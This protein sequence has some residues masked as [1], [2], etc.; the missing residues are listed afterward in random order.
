[1]ESPT[2][3]IF[4]WE[5]IVIKWF[6]YGNAAITLI[7]VLVLIVGL[8][9]LSG[10]DPDSTGTDGS[11]SDGEGQG[12]SAGSDSTAD[13]A[14][15]AAVKLYSKR[16]EPPRG[17][18]QVSIGPTEVLSKQP[19][20]RV[21]RGAWQ[22]SNAIV[23]KLLV[24]GTYS[25]E[26]QD[27]EGWI[28]PKVL[29]TKV[30]KNQ[31]TRLTGTY[32]LPPPMGSLTVAIHPPAAVQAKMR[33]RS[34]I[35]SWQNNGAKVQVP[36]GKHQVSFTPFPGWNTP[37]AI[38]VDV[39][40]DQIT[41]ISG[42]YIEKPKGSLQ[43]FIEPNEVLAQ[44]KWRYA[45]AA[46]QTSGATLE[47]ILAGSYPLELMAVAGWSTPEKAT[48][49]IEPNE[50]TQVLAIYEEKPKGGVRITLGPDSAI[51]AQAQWKLDAG[52]WQNSGVTVAGILV[53]P[54]SISVK[55]LS[56]WIA[57][58]NQTIDITEDQIAEVALVYTLP[59]PP[60]PPPPEFLVKATLIVGRKGMAWIQL[61]GQTKPE[62]YFL[63]EDVAQY[64]ISEI[65]DGYINVK[66]QGHTFKLEVPAPTPIDQLK[67]KPI[68]VKKVAPK[69]PPTPP[70]RKYPPRPSSTAERIR[71]IQ[72]ERAKR[73]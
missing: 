23:E 56:G 24:S 40:K 58:K 54:H 55:P 70:T 65:Y 26:F 49:V 69:K 71:R 7:A 50:V 3:G 35:N 53:G 29:P 38:T 43:V 72:E 39:Q 45:T 63:G 17:S 60:P 5:D 36:A 16:W 42:T 15:V 59:P 73:K 21:N 1:M 25:V 9:Q 20:W 57:P 48:V 13:S 22:E 2:Q 47:K 34:D 46:W 10:I 64:T 31:V 61:T 52:P 33:W 67:P 14:L 6:W 28:K 66:R 41:A 32:R 37:P 27:A 62:I 68:P 44:A 51:Q 11:K 8:G 12:N 30:E 18:I 19:K 4:H